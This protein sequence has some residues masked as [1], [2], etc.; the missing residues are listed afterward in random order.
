MPES[1][2]VEIVRMLYASLGEGAKAKAHPQK[3]KKNI[4]WAE[5]I[6]VVKKRLVEEK[7]VSYP[8]LKKE[9]LVPA[10]SRGQ[11]FERCVIAP[12]IEGH[13]M[14]IIGVKGHLPRNQTLWCLGDNVPEVVDENPVFN[15]P[16]REAAA[17][18]TALAN[19]LKGQVDFKK[20]VSKDQFAFAT[21]NAKM[22]AFRNLVADEAGKEGWM[23]GTRW[24]ATKRN[25]VIEDE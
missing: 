22:K 14:N 11:T 1:E 21:N 13:G 19:G 17:R 9:G 15:E 18:V 23:F 4:S 8:A 6:L 12:L 5:T 25:E 7:Q 24:I 20:L 2:R 16:T 10:N 3:T